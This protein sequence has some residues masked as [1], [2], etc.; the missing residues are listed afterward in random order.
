MNLYNFL[1]SHQ[2]AVLFL[3]GSWQHTQL[4]KKIAPLLLSLLKVV[5]F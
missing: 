3:L 2:I 4:D 5:L 1:L